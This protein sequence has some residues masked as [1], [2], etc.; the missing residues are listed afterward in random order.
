MIPPTVQCGG[1]FPRGSLALLARLFDVP[2]PRVL[3]AVVS[4]GA[5][6]GG[7]LLPLVRVYI[8]VCVRCFASRAIIVTGGTPLTRARLEI[9]RDAGS[10]DETRSSRSIAI[11]GGSI[12]DPELSDRIQ[13][14][15]PALMY[16][17]RSTST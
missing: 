5:H 7:G 12:A 2:S 11:D 8:Y 6:D 4:P 3:P 15:N 13:Q 1:W 17:N 14:R 10:A 16:D 9:A